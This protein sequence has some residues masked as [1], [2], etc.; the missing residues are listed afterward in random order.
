[1]SEETSIVCVVAALKVNRSAADVPEVPP[2]AVTVISTVPAPAGDVAVID[3]AE[4]TVKLAAAVAPNFTAVTPLKF[5]PDIVTGVP[6]LAGPDVGEI[7][8]T[9]GAPK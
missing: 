2:A 5:V 9:V 6:P 3:V 7:A 1:L 4:L 8:V